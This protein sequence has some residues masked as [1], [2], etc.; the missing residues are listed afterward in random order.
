MSRA[1]GGDD[2][3]GSLVP[4]T[5]PT[6]TKEKPVRLRSYQRTRRRKTAAM[7]QAAPQKRPSPD[8]LPAQAVEIILDLVLAAD[9]RRQAKGKRP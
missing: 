7:D 4:E 1:G 2:S 9:A 5:T 3:P 6:T 8:P